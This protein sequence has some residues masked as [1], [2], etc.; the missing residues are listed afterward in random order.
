VVE[1][2]YDE[3][4]FDRYG[5]R[6]N[7]YWFARRF[8]AAIIRRY[9]KRG[10]LL[11]IGCGMGDVLARLEDDFE[12]HGIDVSEYAIQHAASRSPKSDV[13]V[14]TAEQ[15]GELDGPFD[16]IAAFHVVEHLADPFA[17]LKL[18]ARN[19]TPGGLLVFAT[20]NTDAPFA[21]RKGDRWFANT[22]P[23][24]CSL[25]SADEWLELV[26]RAGYRIKRSFS[27]GMWDVPY[28]PLIPAKLQLFM[29]GWPAML[30]TLSTIP[31]IPVAS[32]ESLICVAQKER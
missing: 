2:R 7:Q 24:H 16:V 27:D 3:T 20:P 22:D 13:R 18:C 8:Y 29:F 25:K 4:F 17:V 14:A 30:Q 9:R 6:F 15:I 31:I 10:K 32:G 26:Q 12:T 23:T 5:G 21:K 1:A 28:V 11:E 19:T